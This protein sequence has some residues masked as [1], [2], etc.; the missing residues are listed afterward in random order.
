MDAQTQ[1][2]AYIFPYLGNFGKYGDFSYGVYIVHFPILQILIAVGI[3]DANPLG[4]LVFA[5]VLVMMA[6]YLLW[7]MVEKPFLIKSSHYLAGHRK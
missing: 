4:A 6:A 1:C 3:F 5:S 7:H 2:G